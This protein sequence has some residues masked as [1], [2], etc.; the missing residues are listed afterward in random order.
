LSRRFVLLTSLGSASFAVGCLIAF[1]FTS[2]GEEAG[3]IGKIRDWVIV[4][5]TG[6]TVAKAAAI[7]NLILNFVISAEPNEF[8]L[9]TA[10]SIVFFI[11]G[12]FV[13][14]FPREL[15]LN[16]LLA[17]SRAE[18][19]RLEGTRQAGQIIQSLLAALPA[20]ILSGVDD[21]DEIVEFRKVEAT[22]LRDLLYKPD[23]GK[24]LDEAN[25]QSNLGASLDWDVVSKVAHLHYYRTYFEKDE[26]KVAECERAH[27][28]IVRALSMNPLHVDLTVKL[29]DTLS[30][31][32]R[33]AEA[34]SILEKLEC[35]PEAPA[36][37]KQWLGYFLLFVRRTDDAIKYSE[38][39]HRLFPNE[40]DSLFNIASAY[41]QKY[42]DEVRKTGTANASSPS[43]RAA[44]KKLEEALHAQPD[45]A[46]TV[47]AKWAQKGE[48]FECFAEDNDFR[49]VVGLAE[50]AGRPQT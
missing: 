15:V 27:A 9:A 30:M 18:R 32:E 20:S 39:Y 6:L 7:K 28:W 13:M 33:Y 46:Q 1:L 19:G 42:C 12:F 29:A 23:V 21:V 47:R 10:T 31:V 45:Y 25:E 35:K 5:I 26:K 14:F 11:F 50:K 37:I 16:L 8:A 48:S 49:A 34:V 36:Y 24:F 44:L 17:R 38:E 3:T 22:R 40:S 41:A 43:R 2:H 4:V